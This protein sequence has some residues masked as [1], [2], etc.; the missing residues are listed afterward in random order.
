MPPVTL[1]LTLT[2]TLT[3]TATRFKP[4]PRASLRPT[5]LHLHSDAY[6]RRACASRACA[7]NGA[8]WR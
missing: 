8:G 1:R 6:A 2:L 4:H 7:S 5:M 3:L